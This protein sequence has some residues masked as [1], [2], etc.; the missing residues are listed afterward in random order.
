MNYSEIG[1]AVLDVYDDQ[2]LYKCLESLKFIDQ[3][4]STCVVT[5]KKISNKNF[6]YDKVFTN[7]VG[8]S[9]MRNYCISKFRNSGIK[10]IFILNSNVIIKNKNFI[11]DVIKTCNTFGV[12]FL[13]GTSEGSTVIDD[14][15]KNETLTINNKLNTDFIF[16]RSGII[17]SVGYFDERYINTKDLDVLDYINRLR[18]LNLYPKHPYHITVNDYFEYDKKDIQK[19]SHSDV[20]DGKEPTVGFSYG[21]F[22]HKWNYIPDIDDIPQITKDDLL[23]FLEDCGKNYTQN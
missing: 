15:E 12:W 17:G 14:T 22:K 20:L 9:T 11:E 18:F 7:Q 19:I 3:V 8:F 16:L 1:I 6:I 5:N 10:Y 13:C 23:K 21:Y 2:H 4:A